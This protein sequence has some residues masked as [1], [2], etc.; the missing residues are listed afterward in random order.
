MMRRLPIVLL[1]LLCAAV[2]AQAQSLDAFRQRLAEPAASATLF[3]RAQVTVT[4]HGDAARAV[5]DAARAAQKLHIDG[6]RV[7]IFSD[8]GP[9]ARDEAFAAKELFETTYPGIEVYAVYNPPPYFRVM[10]G[11]CLTREEAIILMNKV[12]STFPKA[13]PKAEKLSL[14]DFLD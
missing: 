3:G 11:N 1:T 14:S 4:E 2:S 8:N 12:L 10:I 7:C 13:Y 9:K 5:A 6:Y